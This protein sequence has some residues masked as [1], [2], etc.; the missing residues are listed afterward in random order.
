MLGAGGRRR[1]DEG[2]GEVVMRPDLAGRALWGQAM[3]WGERSVA[4]EPGRRNG[5]K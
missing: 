3:R 4:F 2:G 1:G 5:K